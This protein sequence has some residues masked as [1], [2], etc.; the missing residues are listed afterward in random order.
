MSD[1]TVT[2][3]RLA[4]INVLS[5]VEQRL[6]EIERLAAEFPELPMRD[7]LTVAEYQSAKKALETSLGGLPDWLSHNERLDR[8]ANG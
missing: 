5:L 3:S 7:P 6:A 8:A 4:A 2:F 1:V